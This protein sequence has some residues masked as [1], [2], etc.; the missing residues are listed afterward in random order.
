MDTLVPVW[1]CT[2]G[3]AAATTLAALDEA[4][5]GLDT[6]VVELWEAFGQ[7]GKEKLCV[8]HLLA[9]QAGLAALTD[10]PPVEDYAA[11]I[12]ALEEAAPLWSVGHGYHTRTY[13]FL[14]DEIVRRATGAASL[15]HYW[16]EA[17]AEPLG[18]DAWIGLPESEHSR[19]A[20]LVPGKFGSETGGSPF[21]QGAGRPQEFDVSDVLVPAGLA[22]G[23]GYERSSGLARGLSGLWW[24]GLGA[25]FSGVL[26]RAGSGRALLGNGVFQ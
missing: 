7:A 10:P 15:G 19:V 22:F 12:R 2:K 21:L 13:G 26:W 5:L 18:I 4:G 3:L 25:R 23:R 8:G 9:H 16:R 14:L 20:E 24:C 11:V 1:S 6:P 17:M